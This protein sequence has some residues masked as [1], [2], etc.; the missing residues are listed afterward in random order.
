[1][2]EVTF[3]LHMTITP[4]SLARIDEYL[5]LIDEELER[6]LNDI[7]AHLV[8]AIKGVI[9]QKDILNTGDLFSSIAYIID[10]VPGL[11]TGGSGGSLVAGTNKEYGRYVE[12]GTSPHFVPFHMALSLYNQAQG[13]WGWLPVTRKAGARLNTEMNAKP[14]KAIQVDADGLVKV[15]GRRQTYYLDKHPERLWLRPAPGAKPTWGVFVSG[16]K[17]PFIY[18][19]FEESVAWIEERLNEAPQ[20]ALARLGGEG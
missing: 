9:K 18:P 14:S 5:R 2:S 7:G 16:E 6:A 10:E 19:G 17:Q 11:S 4:E 1:M 8:E 20:R 3:D 12:L 15:T 13:Q